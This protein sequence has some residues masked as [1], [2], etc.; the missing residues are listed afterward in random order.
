VVSS[1]V[2]EVRVMRG[3]HVAKDATT[4]RH[5]TMKN[6]TWK[7]HFYNSANILQ[8]DGYDD[9]FHEISLIILY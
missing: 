3:V 5:T 8:D 6:N 1:L 2:C 9:L 4:K 7:N